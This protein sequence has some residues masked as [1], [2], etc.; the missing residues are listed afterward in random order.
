MI[1]LSIQTSAMSIDTIIMPPDF[2]GIDKPF[3]SCTGKFD[4]NYDFNSKLVNSPICVNGELLDSVYWLA[5]P[6]EPDEY[7]A[8]RL[9]KLLGWNF[10]DDTS[11]MNFMHPNPDTFFYPKHID[12]LCW[13]SNQHIM[14]LGTGRPYDPDCEHL[15]IMFSDELI[16][17]SSSNCDAGPVGCYKILRLWTI[18]DSC[19]S[20]MTLKIQIIKVVDNEGPTV[21]YPDSIKVNTESNACLGRWEVSPAWLVDNCSN[22]IHYRVEVEH[23]FILGDETSGY[24]AVNLPTG[25]QIAKIIGEDCCGNITEKEVILIVEDNTPPN[26]V[27]DSKTTVSISGNQAPGKNYAKIF[28]HDLGAGSIEN[29]DTIYTK[30]IRLDQLKGTNNGSNENQDDTGST[31][32]LINGDDNDNID[33]NQIYFDDEA[34]FCCS[35]VNETI[36]L[37][38]RVFDRNP[39][40]GPVSPILM[41]KGGFLYN[42][43]SDCITQVEIQDKTVPTLVAPPNIVVSCAFAFDIDQLTNPNDSI[44]G[45]VVTDLSLRKKVS[46]LD[47]VCH[48]YCVK[49]PKTGY[50]GNEPGSPPS[51][52]PAP[53]RACDYYQSLFDTAHSGLK[54]TLVW[55]FDG[56]LLS[57]CDNVPTIEVTDNRICGQGKIIR[58]ITALGS[59]GIKVTTSQTIWVVDC[60]PFYINRN[61]AC[62]P[63]D[64]I[65][66]PGNCDGTP[67]IISDCTIDTSPDNPIVGKPIIR[68]GEID[69]CST[70]TIEYADLIIATT[71]DTCFNIIRTWTVTDECQYDPSIDSTLGKWLYVQQI[72][73]LK[74]TATEDQEKSKNE[75]IIM[76]NPSTGF[77][78][79]KSMNKIDQIQLISSLGK[80]VLTYKISNEHFIDLHTLPSGLYFVQAYFKGAQIATAK[81][82]VTN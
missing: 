77:A 28:A 51:N 45:R 31:C 38:V 2:D 48:N 9:P 60:D 75:L 37:V 26:A 25:M 24:V 74:I 58:K 78:Q 4:K 11:S 50:P 71:P 12:S 15:E 22:E 47:K 76:P 61:D 65:T 42:H 57:A 73:V 23:G 18:Y 62:D 55:G 10:I 43:F 56:Y 20:N 5:H 36:T 64:D 14:A 44:F 49:N 13:N 79:I 30:I 33:G 70:I 46:T 8:R 7:P 80:S 3:F 6:N 41:N 82:I 17:S 27:C 59:N 29:C 32:Y 68:V 1:S 21:L 52:P 69:N 53:V 34:T 35:E 54:F 39:G 72:K 66:W 40:A 16:K 81:L 67:I 19:I 63:N